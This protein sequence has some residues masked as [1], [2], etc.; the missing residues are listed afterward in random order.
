L[1]VIAG[2]IVWAAAVLI[3]DPLQ[4]WRKRFKEKETRK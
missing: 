1:V 3:S 2:L 4:V